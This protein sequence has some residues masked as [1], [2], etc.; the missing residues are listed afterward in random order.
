LANFKPKLAQPG[1]PIR[2][3]DW[4]Y[5][6]QGLLDDIAQLEA[7]YAELRN[8]VDNMSE[9]NTVTNLDS[10]QGKAYRLDEA[11]P[12]E[13]GTYET[14]VLGYITKQWMAPIRGIAD[15]CR[16]TLTD[17]FDQLDF[18]AGAENGNRSALDVTLRY[19]DGTTEAIKGLYVHDRG[20]LQP[21]GADNPYVGFLLAPN[22]RVWY[23]YRIKNPQPTR[24]VLSVTFKNTNPDCAARIGNVV[25]LRTRVKQLAV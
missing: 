3:E 7:K 21:K 18:W 14:P 11:V 25:H 5:I 15:V 16:F 23:R 20:K 2:S 9:V 8:Y 6:Q 13:K 12:G 17:T 4:N 19:A 10:P 24:E 1:E 22:Q